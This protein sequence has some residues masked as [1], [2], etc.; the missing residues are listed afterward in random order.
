ME[1]SN[2]FMELANSASGRILLAIFIV[3]GIVI[4]LIGAKM[5]SNF[6]Y[7][8]R[9]NAKIVGE[10]MAFLYAFDGEELV[11]EKPEEVIDIGRRENGGYHLT[12]SDG[13]IQTD[14]VVVPQNYYS[15]FGEKR[16]FHESK[17]IN[18]LSLGKDGEEQFV[19]VVGLRIES[20]EEIKKT[21][22]KYF[23][24]EFALNHP[25]K[26]GKYYFTV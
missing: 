2:F 20:V 18:D 8:W 22:N 25:D 3:G 19:L 14:Y 9:T 4:L 12:T 5:L 17:V 13:F 7:A 21:V 6:I 15:Q 26:N 1:T 23:Q 10:W 24:H 11:E 16:R